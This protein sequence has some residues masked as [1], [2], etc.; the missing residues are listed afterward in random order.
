VNPAI[1]PAGIII[2]ALLLAS[3][4]A[5]A[6]V[7]SNSG[8]T[9]D[10]SATVEQIEAAITALGAREG[11]E[12][13]TRSK[14]VEQLRDAQAQVQKR[15]SAESAA[16]EFAT[17]MVSAPAETEVL[18]TALDNEPAAA[19]TAESLGIDD[20]ITLVELERRLTRETADV[21]AVQSRLEDLE[22]KIEIELG[23]P[24]QARERIYQLR[25]GRAELGAI[26]DEPPVPGESRVL[27]DA[28]K[29]AALLRR[30]AQSAETSMLEQA[31]LSYTVRLDLL[32]AQR[33]SVAR[34][35]VE[36]HQRVELLRTIVN[37]R[38]QFAAIVTQ[39]GALAAEQA[40]AD[41]HQ[42]V[43]NL[44]EANASLTRA[45]PGIAADI[46]RETGKLNQ[47]A[48]AASDIERRL[49]RSQ[50]RLEVGG[51]SR[52]I[53]R[54]LLAE[55]RN[56]PKVSQYRAEVRA[57]GTKLAE[58]GLAQ[59]QVQ[60][61]RRELT[62]I[63]A[64]VREL[65]V[66]VDTDTS[67]E[68]ELVEIRIEIGQ[69]LRARRNLLS[70]ADDY[71]GGYLQVLGDLDIAQRRLLEAVGDHQD[72][73]NQN[74]LWIPSAP[75][76]F[77]G[78]WGMI[79]PG[80]KWAFSRESWQASV[81]DAYESL[82]ENIV[83]AVFCVLMLALVLLVRRP[84][85]RSQKT[86]S[87][88]IGRLS[89]DHIG[90]TV[91]ALAIAAVRV[92]PVP[93]LFGA[94]EW[95]LTNA[96]QPSTFSLAV[97]RSL[98]LSAALLYNLLLFR[99]FSNPTGVLKVHFGWQEDNLAIIRR[100]L[101][102]LIYVAVPLV[103]ITIWLFQSESA[104][105]RAAFGRLVFIALLV[106]LAF[107][108]RSL[109]HPVTGVAGNYYKRNAETWVSKLR[110]FWYALAVGIP[111]LLGL[112]SVLGYVYA[113]VILLGLLAD[114][115]WLLLALIIVNLV[116][117][118][119]L[120]LTRRKLA[121]Q[122]ALKERE[123]QKAEREKEAQ[124]ETESEAPQVTPEPLDLD[125]VDQQT[126]KL[127]RAALLIV[128]VLAGWRIW[129]EMFPAFT[130]LDQVALWSQT[131][132]VD[133]VKTIAPV[134]LADLFLALLVVA[135]TAIASKNLPGLMEIAVLRHLTLEPGSQYA[136]ITLVRYVVVTV[137]AISVLNIVGW[138][139][140]QIQWL[141]AALSVGLGFGLQEI[142]A[143]FVSG[144]VILFERPVRVGDTV[145]VGQ[146]TGT[147]SR[148]R[149][150]ATTIIDW[151]RKEIIVPNKS[152]ITEQVVNWTLSDPI[153]RIVVP[154]GVS[155]GSDVDLVQKVMADT[156][157]SL[158]LVMEEPPPRV[159]FTG[160]GDSSL[161]FTVQVYLRQLT[162][163][164]PL[165]HSVHEAILK[166]LRENGIEIPFPQH[167]LHIRSTIEGGTPLVR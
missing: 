131:V 111:V 141:V 167:D 108:F 100:Q 166:A 148:V 2:V 82:R 54:L 165:T 33:D 109:S 80:A 150:R 137:G 86:M 46:E 34:S 121:L 9:L 66:E 81:A 127:L 101:D 8:V 22:A 151:D 74:L 5:A 152:F 61:K 85:A 89:T 58:I 138:N 53:G 117:L 4:P 77:T 155:Y 126:R 125:A 20:D 162:D 79:V 157:E 145:T 45:L 38:R 76:A 49:A 14:A 134:T 90:L 48:G 71:Y 12:T 104:E 30:D 87:A 59:I 78:E 129:A 136:T 153:T 116:V 63:D 106:V 50:K 84:L 113:S 43:R 73:L 3:L 163:R 51:L 26:I 17:A 68:E 115:I 25:M 18:R 146:L 16:A 159:Y 1:R 88:R 139:W 142:V 105:D 133:G 31:I 10:A 132:V 7:Y 24:T 39:Q 13:E 55:R 29:F 130:L 103:F 57:R 123:A 93:L 52:A 32:K 95:F 128:G 65:M 15:L 161:N 156:V 19:A 118:R 92:L 102:R 83:A 11:L 135:L 64:T 41:K 37:E 144:L 56:L 164:L 40:A 114:T 27:A 160:F 120:A 62:S 94:T 122:I 124:S 44:A 67:D 28:R 147:V 119:W 69:L 91:A 99:A 143:N 110:W 112:M 98:S 158:P 70:Q 149:I 107:V 96:T 47:I 60:E 140:S 35:Q 6:Q 75:I 23:R 154:V 97:A 36:G 72:F 21:A 42:I